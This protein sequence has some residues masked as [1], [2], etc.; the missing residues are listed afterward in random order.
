MHTSKNKQ[1]ASTHGRPPAG[2][3]FLCSKGTDRWLGDEIAQV[4]TEIVTHDAEIGP[5][6]YRLMRAPIQHLRGIPS[7]W[8]VNT[9]RN[10]F[11]TRIGKGEA[12]WRE[13]QQQY[14]WK[15]ATQNL[16]MGLKVYCGRAREYGAIF[17]ER[18]S[19]QGDARGENGSNLSSTI[20]CRYPHASSD[21]RRRGGMTGDREQRSIMDQC[22]TM[23]REGR[24]IVD[25]DR[26]IDRDRRS[27]IGSIRSPI[28]PAD[29]T[30]DRSHDRSRGSITLLMDRR[31]RHL[32]IDRQ[33]GPPILTAIDPHPS[34]Y[35]SIDAP[36]TL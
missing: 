28:D 17:W 16:C 20:V 15:R 12:G 22:A 27:E 35:F 14:S 9:Q 3:Y 11:C 8:R 24:V 10:A 1:S 5:T 21:V 25:H 6:R 13:H 30:H 19:E 4:W 2:G 7:I 23:I 26:R 33:D 32:R 29:R 18:H 34:D 36:L 31:N